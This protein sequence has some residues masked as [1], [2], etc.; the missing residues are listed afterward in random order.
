M[1]IKATVTRVIDGDTVVLVLRARLARE[2]APEIETIP[3]QL[4]ASDLR[5]RLLHKNVL[6]FIHG[7]D[8]HGRALVTLTVSPDKGV[9]GYKTSRKAR[10]PKDEA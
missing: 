5:T 6:A 4:A 10:Q 9:R 1:R 2:N 3:G 7:A 8:S